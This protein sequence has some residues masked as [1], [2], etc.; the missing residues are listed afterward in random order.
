M[1]SVLEYGHLI[2]VRAAP[3]GPLARFENRPKTAFSADHT[4]FPEDA[5]ALGRRAREQQQPAGDARKSSS[6][7]VYSVAVGNRLRT[8]HTK[9]ALQQQ[10][11]NSCKKI[12]PRFPTLTTTS[13]FLPQA[14]A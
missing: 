2:T 8:L 12:P 13:S 14:G 6:Q 9:K 3:L 4:G 7:R 10:L 1:F 11:K 5:R